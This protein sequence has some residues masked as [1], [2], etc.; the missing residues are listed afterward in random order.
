MLLNASLEDEETLGLDLEDL[1]ER[2]VPDIPGILVGDK[3][4]HITLAQ[5]QELLALEKAVQW[6]RDNEIVK[7]P[8]YLPE[9][10]ENYKCLVEAGKM[11]DTL[12]AYA[13]AVEAER[14][15]PPTDNTWLQARYPAA[16]D[17]AAAEVLNKE[18]SANQEDDD[19]TE[20]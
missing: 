12:N 7:G 16:C 1:E 10:E 14:S 20:V 3:E 19:A 15:A 5:K 13:G 9:H 17:A 6:L 18:P 11:K 4:V 8:G 2:L